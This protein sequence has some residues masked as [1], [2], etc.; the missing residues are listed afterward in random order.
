MTV[1]VSYFWQND[2]D[3]GYGNSKFT[4]NGRITDYDNVM[5]MQDY[6]KQEHNYK[7]VVILFWEYLK[8]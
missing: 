3:T 1:F 4:I 2:N 8:E 7:N 5:A 6:L